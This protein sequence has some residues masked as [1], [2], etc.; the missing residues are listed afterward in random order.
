MPVDARLPESHQC[1]KNALE[2]PW[3]LILQTKFFTKPWPLFDSPKRILSPP[4]KRSTAF[5]R[6]HTP[7]SKR[8]TGAAY[9]M[10]Q[11]NYPPHAGSLSLQSPGCGEARWLRPSEGTCELAGVSQ[12]VPTVQY[13]YACTYIYIC[14]LKCIFICTYIYIYTYTYV[15]TYMYIH[16][17]VY[18][19]VYPSPHLFFI[20][21]YTQIPIHYFLTKHMKV[22]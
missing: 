4:I 18:L 11:A 5:P 1:Q 13:M 22:Y 15:Y 6:S 10:A 2:I 14:M 20:Y 9:Q 8:H 16:L 7:K 12:Y 3:H 19:S 21:L 17:S